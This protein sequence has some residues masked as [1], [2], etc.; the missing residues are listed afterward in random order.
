[1]RLQK[2]QDMAK[3]GSLGKEG[4]SSQVWQKGSAQAPEGTRGCLTPRWAPAPQPK[5]G[6]GSLQRDLSIATSTLVAAA[7]EPR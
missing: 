2:A 5:A 4:T 3:E 6:A 7:S 1:M